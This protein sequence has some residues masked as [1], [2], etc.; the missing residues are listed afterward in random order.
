MVL[1]TPL[2]ERRTRREMK[3][4]GH[5]FSPNFWYFFD[6]GGLTNQILVKKRFIFCVKNSPFLMESVLSHPGSGPKVVKVVKVLKLELHP[7]KWTNI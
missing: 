2:P 7:K 4:Q 1:Y 3:R 5:R 6:F